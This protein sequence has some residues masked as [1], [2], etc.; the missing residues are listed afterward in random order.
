MLIDLNPSQF[1]IRDN[2][3]FIKD[4]SKPFMLLIHQEWCGHCV[5]FMPD[6]LKLSNMTN[7]FNFFKLNGDLLNKNTALSN[8]LKVEGYPT[9]LFGNEK[10]LI[11][12]EYNGN[13]DIVSLSNKIKSVCKYCF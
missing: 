3:V 10:G 6:Y 7:R 9:I 13:R 5:H 4:T 12:E 2:H 8:Q 1:Y 11:V